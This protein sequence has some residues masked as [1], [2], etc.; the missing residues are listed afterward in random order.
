MTGGRSTAWGW[1]TID[2]PPRRRT[3]QHDGVCDFPDEPRMQ[4][5]PPEHRTAWKNDP[6]KK[7]GYTSQQERCELAALLDLRPPVHCQGVSVP[8]DSWEVYARKAE[9]EVG[10][11]EPEH[12][13]D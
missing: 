8:P 6:S 12:H 9:G 7:Y 11:H 2:A 10:L 1:L 4:L 5:L 13:W 3:W